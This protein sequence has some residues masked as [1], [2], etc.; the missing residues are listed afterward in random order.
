MIRSNGRFGKIGMYLKKTD[1]N[2]KTIVRFTVIF[3]M[4]SLAKYLIEQKFV[5]QNFRHHVKISSIF[6]PRN[7]FVRQIVLCNEF[8]SKTLVRCNSCFC[9]ILGKNKE[10]LNRHFFT[11]GNCWNISTITLV[12]TYHQFRNLWKQLYAIRNKVLEFVHI[13]HWSIP[14]SPS[15][16]SIFDFSY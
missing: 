4:T 15:S 7:I 8:S 10:R 5:G 6:C 2:H 11:W 13:R 16:V 14:Y 12:K 3:K 9:S 1:K